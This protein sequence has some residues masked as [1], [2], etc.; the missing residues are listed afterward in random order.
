MSAKKK[1][2]LEQKRVELEENKFHKKIHSSK[3]KKRKQLG[4]EM[5][6]FA[7]NL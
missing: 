6:L 5:S 3:G 1:R 2:R 7:G 4:I